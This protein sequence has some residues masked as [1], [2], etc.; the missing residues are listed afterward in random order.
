[1]AYVIMYLAAIITA[2]LLI[3]QLGPDWSVLTAFLFIGLDLTARDRL[4]DAW[5]GSHLW[6]KMA[7][8][9]G[10]GSVLSWLANAGAGQIAAASFIA[11]AGAGLVDALGYH[12]VRHWFRFARVNASNVP[13][14]AVDSFLFPLLAFGW[15]PLWPIMVGQFVAKVGGGFVWAVVLEGA[16]W[17]WQNR[18]QLVSFFHWTD[19]TPSRHRCV[20]CGTPEWDT[21]EIFGEI[22]GV[23]RGCAACAGATYFARSPWLGFP[24]TIKAK[25][26]FKRRNQSVRPCP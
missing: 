4:H 25:A 20:V 6:P 7:L 21:V 19:Y 3:A 16:S 12:V 10:A 22:Y 1:M 8:L 18:R 9:I 26:F 13:S 14:A 5:R 17:L 23:E 11:F 15:P 2:N 24:Y